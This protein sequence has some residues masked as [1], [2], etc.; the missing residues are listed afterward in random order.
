MTRIAAISTFGSGS[1]AEVYITSADWMPRNLDRR[2][3]A[4]VPLESWSHRQMVK[5]QLEL[6]LTDNRQAWDLAA[7]GTWT[8][9]TPGEKEVAT[10]KALAEWYK[11]LRIE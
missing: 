9:R 8:Q 5:D 1:S 10:H 7:D 2:I 6:M 4:A 11:G 3:E